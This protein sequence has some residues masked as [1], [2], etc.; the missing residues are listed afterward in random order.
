MEVIVEQE[1]TEGSHAVDIRIIITL[2]EVRVVLSLRCF[3]LELLIEMLSPLFCD[4]IA[5]LL[6]LAYEPLCC[7]LFEVLVKRRLC[8]AREF[9]QP[10]PRCVLLLRTRRQYQN[11]V[12]HAFP[13]LVELVGKPNLYN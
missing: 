3:E 12:F 4:R 7:E 13:S 1:P 2:E 8:H 10:A 6:I 5:T 11:L 9:E